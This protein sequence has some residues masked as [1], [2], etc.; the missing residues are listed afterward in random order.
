M[1]GGKGGNNHKKNRHRF[2]GRR[3]DSHKNDRKKNPDSNVPEEKQDKDMNERQ[4]WTAPVQPVNP[5]ILMNCHWCGKQIKDISTAISDKESGLPV[6]FDCVLSRI[7]E[8]ESLGTNECVSYIGGGRFG[9]IRYNNPPDTRDFTI[10]KIF[11]WELK[12][13][14]HEW[15]RPISEFF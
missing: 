8:T 14:T 6:H 2:S 15:R 5:V 10:K 9:V 7:I 13:I 3:N 1:N 11:E 12:D 4:R